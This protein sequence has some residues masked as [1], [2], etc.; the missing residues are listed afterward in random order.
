VVA[1]ETGEVDWTAVRAGGLGWALGARCVE[2]GGWVWLV[3][4]RRV[5]IGGAVDWTE[6]GIRMGCK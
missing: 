3:S 1:E 5:V 6:G 2:W 4:V